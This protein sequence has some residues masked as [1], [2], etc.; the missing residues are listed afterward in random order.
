M[1]NYDV[2]IIGGGLLGCF[3]ARSLSRHSLRIGL[4]EKN[5]DVCMGISKANTAIVYPGYDQKPGSLKAWLTVE[6]CRAFPA[7]CRELDVPYRQ[8]GSLMVACGPRGAQVLEEKLAQGVQNG[9]GDLQ[10]LSAA[11]TL[12]LE[13]NLG[14]SALCA[15]YAPRAGTVNAWELCIAAAE[16]AA[17]NGVD[18]MLN[19]EVASIT[20]LPQ[21]GFQV[22]TGADTYTCRALVN[23]AGLF[24]DRV[25]NMVASPTFQLR[26]S[27]ADYLVLDDSAGNFIRHIVLHE[28]EADGKGATLVPTVDGNLLL[29]PSKDESPGANAEN[30]TTWQGLANV[31]EAVRAVV[32]GLP[33][34][35]VIRSFSALRPELE[36]VAPGT[37]G[38]MHPTGERVH[39]FLIFRPK[40]A[41][42]MVTLAG[43]KTP[44]LTCVDAI[45]HHVAGMVLD[46]LGPAQP[47]TRFSPLRRG[48]ARFSAA[49]P[50]E[51]SRLAE[52]DSRYGHVVCRCRQVTEAEIAEAIR[53]TPGAATL[54][55][56]KR[57]TGAGM[58]R[59]Q[60]GY[61]ACETIKILAAA[62]QRPV[63]QIE[64]DAPGSAV[65]VREKHCPPSR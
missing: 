49:S 41:P 7:L 36:L 8:C 13:P 23:C 27:R 20:A 64:Q 51:K 40:D 14:E 60:G 37:D 30:A 46:I 4:L 62:L 63:S 58:G 16:N 25:H 57:R 18:I 11:E 29:G 45:G 24:A 54:D 43:I 52:A 35:Q 10:L 39:D 38:A 9:L 22:D 33:A 3:T 32:P 65:I 55:G 21:G 19:A 26:I 34:S 31:A 5:P 1:Q 61:C 47:N 50:A 42:D 59:C 17:A 12:A 6:A 15:L 56:V 48:I 53:R 2:L 44:G 28:P